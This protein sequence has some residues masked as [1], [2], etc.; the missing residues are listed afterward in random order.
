MRLRLPEKAFARLSIKGFVGAGCILPRHRVD[1]SHARRVTRAS[2]HAIALSFYTTRTCSKGKGDTCGSRSY[3][4]SQLTDPFRV[5]SA[6]HAAAF[7]L[8]FGNSISAPLS[9]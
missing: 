3:L 4:R 7:P 6:A 5:G 9:R 8:A 2:L 1:V